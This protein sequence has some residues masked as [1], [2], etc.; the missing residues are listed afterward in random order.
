M[1]KYNSAGTSV[2]SVITIKGDYYLKVYYKQEKYVCNA[3]IQ[4]PLN[5]S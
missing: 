3:F 5:E 2:E 4:K 1:N